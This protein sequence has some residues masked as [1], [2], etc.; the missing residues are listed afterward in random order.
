MKLLT[1]PYL[2]SLHPDREMHILWIQPEQTDCYIEYGYTEALG[3][4]AEVNCYEI[5][6][7]RG[8]QADGA[9]GT[10]P[11]GHPKISV[12]QYIGKLTDLIPGKTVYYRCCY[13]NEC[14]KTY[15]FRV[16]PPAG[17]D[18]TFA[19]I[20]DLQLL[21]NCD[22]T[23]HQI[24]CF[25]PD[26]ILFSGDATYNAWQI[27]QWFDLDV[28][29]QT[30]ETKR[31]AFFPCMQQENGARLMQHAPL[32]F[33]PGNH[34]PDFMWCCYGVPFDQTAGLW[35]WSIFMQLFRPL[36]P[37]T[38]WGEG[39][40]RWYSANYADLH[41]TSLSVNRQSNY[42]PIRKNAWLQLDPIGPGTPQLEWLKADLAQDNAKF[43]WVIQHFH[44]LNKAWDAQ[45]NLCPP[46]LD[47][48]GEPTYPE[49]YGQMLIDLF[50]EHKVNAVSYGHSHVYERYFTKGTHYIEAAY[51][52]KT[53]ADPEMPPHPSGLLPVFE[54]NSR[55]SFVIFRRQKGGIFA[56]GYYVDETPIQFDHYQIA[57]EEGN[58]VDPY[59]KGD[60]Q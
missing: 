19:Q 9:Y 51:L 18:Y 3:N 11:K 46:V 45:F 53:F 13:G 27:E 1:Q 17:E 20:S 16:A 14:T 47:E 29:W 48:N 44:I 49:D 52:S 21:P 28:P 33:A 26:F 6:G 32:F 10:S 5:T 30:E 35:N 8:P 59:A 50:S 58:S 4:R 60:N 36:Y 34:E 2:L 43:K 12:W 22:T 55:R 42:L 54:D 38:N 37:D 31:K 39:G 23:I 57:D 25:H 56:T 40:K 41:I 24:G 15:F 7:L